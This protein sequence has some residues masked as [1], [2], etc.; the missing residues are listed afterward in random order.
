MHEV[1]IME[2]TL[3]IALQK[4]KE[5]GANQIHRIKMTVGA[6]SGVAVE[7]LE[8]AFDVVVAG[9]IAAKAKFEIDYLPVRCYCQHCNQEFEPKTWFYECPQCGEPSLDI[10]QGRELE[11]TSLEVS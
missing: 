9:T 5:Q 4:A 7:A 3:A 8:F 10:R 11:L 2:Q 6:D 1:G